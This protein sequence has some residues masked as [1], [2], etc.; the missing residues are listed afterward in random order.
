MQFIYFFL[1]KKE[2]KK[3]NDNV[4]ILMVVTKRLCHMIFGFGQDL[5]IKFVSASGASE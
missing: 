4:V 3:K 5:V 1:S 2:E